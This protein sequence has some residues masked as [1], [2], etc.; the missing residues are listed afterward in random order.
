MSLAAYIGRRSSPPVRLVYL[1]LTV[2]LLGSAGE[3]GYLGRDVCAGCHKSIA[4]SH[5]RTNM[6]RSWQGAASQQIASN[7]YDTF[8]EGPQPAI[9]YALKK[10]GQ[11]L[12]FR[13]QM[14]GHPR[15]DF[16]VEAV[17]GGD[18]HG[19]SFLFR[20]PAVEGLP[21]PLSRLLE[22]RYFHYAQQDK[23]ALSR[24]HRGVP[25][26]KRLPVLVCHSRPCGE[27]ASSR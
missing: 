23:L 27:R 25:N 20:V 6:A 8:A 24:P 4:A 5:L 16:P 3:S 10:T 17:V 19:V 7:Y 15:H 12:E 21:L 9:E 11:S 13:A 2:R 14:P 1:L 26:G 22:A 18:R